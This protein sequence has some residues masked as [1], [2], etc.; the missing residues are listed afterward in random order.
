M[1][2]LLFPLCRSFETVVSVDVRFSIC[3]TPLHRYDAVTRCMRTLLRC[4]VPQLYKASRTVNTTRTS[5]MPAPPT[6]RRARPSDKS[7]EDT[8]GPRAVQV[9]RALDAKPRTCSAS[10]GIER[11]FWEAFEAGNLWFANILLVCE[12]SGGV[13]ATSAAPQRNEPTG[14]E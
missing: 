13:R 8:C 3:A 4:G 9:C 7:P 5:P 2:L 11:G 1:Q 12:R 14:A 10:S 6:A